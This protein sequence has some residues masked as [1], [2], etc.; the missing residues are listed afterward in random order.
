MI[1]IVKI[2]EGESEEIYVLLEKKVV[3]GTLILLFKKC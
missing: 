2:I 3:E 1:K